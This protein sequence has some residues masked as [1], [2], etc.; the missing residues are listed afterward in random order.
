VE[1]E[2]KVAKWTLASSMGRDRDKDGRRGAHG[3]REV[4]GGRSAESIGA[5]WRVM[6]EPPWHC[7]THVSA[8][9]PGMR[10]LGAGWPTS[11]PSAA[12]YIIKDF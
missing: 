2:H 11:G 10:L 1:R 7:H 6:A 5:R 3:R 12:N 8:H 4:G 9:W